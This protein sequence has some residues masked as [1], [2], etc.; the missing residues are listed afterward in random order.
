MFQFINFN[1]TNFDVILTWSTLIW[2]NSDTKNKVILSL[3][4]FMRLTF[5]YFSFSASNSRRPKAHFS[6]LYS[7]NK[8]HKRQ[9]GNSISVR[10]TSLSGLLI[11][12]KKKEKNVFIDADIDAFLI[13]LYST[14]SNHSAKVIFCCSCLSV[15][16]VVTLN[17]M[18]T[19]VTSCINLAPC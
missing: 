1:Y 2:I 6:Q 14:R 11:T 17:V 7:T 10:G 13:F 5:V 19:C 15:T 3:Y 16:T 9:E 8:K 4:Q 12:V 18:V